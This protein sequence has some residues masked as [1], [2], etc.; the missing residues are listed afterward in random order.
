MYIHVYVHNQLHTYM[1][2]H[3]SVCKVVQL[4]HILVSLTYNTCNYL[5]LFASSSHVGWF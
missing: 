3:V 2:V 5:L 4:T 1:Y